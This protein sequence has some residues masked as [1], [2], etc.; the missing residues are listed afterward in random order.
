MKDNKTAS[1]A[2]GLRYVGILVGIAF[3]VLGVMSLV[4]KTE[5]QANKES[6]I[7]FAECGLLGLGII[8]VGLGFDAVLNALANLE[9]KS[10]KDSEDD[11][12]DFLA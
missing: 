9:E 2:K 5:D 3:L 1:T 11:G 7:R 10:S 6:I 12:T 8:V 4:L